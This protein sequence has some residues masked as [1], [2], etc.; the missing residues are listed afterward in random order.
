[1]L[2]R[3]EKEL[4]KE[5]V[6]NLLWEVGMKIENEEINS[7]LLK[8]GCSQSS[9]GRIR[10]PKEMIEELVSVQKKTQKEDEEDQYLYL[11]CGVDWTHFILWTN[12]KKEIK[13]QL[14]QKFMMS[15]FDCGPTKFYDYPHQKALAVDT[16]IFVEMMKFAHSTPEIGYIS[17]WYR[18]DISPKIER[19]DSLILG[20]KHTDKVDGIESIYPEQIKYLQEIGE[21][22]SDETGNTPY[23]AGSQCITSPLILEKR[24]AAEMIERVK[25]E[26]K[27]F[28]ICSMPTIGVSTPVTLAGSIVMGAAEILGGMVA[29]FNMDPEADLSGR[30][31]STVV[32]MKTG[33]TTSSGP[34]VAAVNLGVKELFDACFGGHLWVDVFFSPEAKRPGLQAVY[35][36]FYG[37]HCYSKL[38]GNPDICYPGMG[39]LDNGGMGSPTQ[40]MLDME[41]RKSQFALKNKISINKESLPFEEICEKVRGRKEFLSSDHTLRHFRELWSSKIFLTDE[42]KPGVWEG[43]EKSILDKCD[44]LW[45]ENIKKYEPPEWPKEKL[46]ALDKLLERAKKEL[47]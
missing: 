3:E 32:D 13:K 17:T 6:Y 42:P 8:N 7:I 20:L 33:N 38:I 47:L 36:N 9:S 37:L 44:E 23:L 1:M 30:M 10:I 15:A 19:I 4:L 34:E 14:G 24:S 11:T 12:K 45:R 46:R 5:K 2:S 18:Q 43:N 16:K 29:A 35:E 22:I 21:I 41:I 31:I 28:H 40:F 26:I 25:R 39:T 27:R